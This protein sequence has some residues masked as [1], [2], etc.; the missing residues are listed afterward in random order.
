MTLTP[1]EP[2]PPAARCSFAHCN[3][4]RLPVHQHPDAYH[5]QISVQPGN[6][7]ADEL[8]PQIHRHLSRGILFLGADPREYGTVRIEHVEVCPARPCPGHPVL[9]A[10]WRRL[11]IRYRREQRTRLPAPEDANYAGKPHMFTTHTGCEPS[12]G[13]T[14][15]THIESGP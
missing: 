6:Y 12:N 10:L 1:E 13:G 4:C 5:R 15:V 9:A 11:A 8:P 14:T 3:D 2:D 7:P